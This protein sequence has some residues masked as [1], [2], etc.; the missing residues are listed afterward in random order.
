MTTKSHHKSDSVPY[1][2]SFPPIQDYGIVGNCHAA[3]LVSSRG[4]IDWLC[5]PRFDSPSV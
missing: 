5:L 1:T 2:L 4:S 3:A